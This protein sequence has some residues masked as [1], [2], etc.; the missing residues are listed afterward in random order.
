M[1]NYLFPVQTHVRMSTHP[2]RDQA[3]TKISS[4]S[5]RQSYSHQPT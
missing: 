3:V 1:L 5:A 4:S 2:K